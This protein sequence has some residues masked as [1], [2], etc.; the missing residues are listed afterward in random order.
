MTRLHRHY[1]EYRRVGFSR[2]NAFHF[3]WLVVMSGARP[4]QVRSPTGGRG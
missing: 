4:V 2:F 1:L 3:A